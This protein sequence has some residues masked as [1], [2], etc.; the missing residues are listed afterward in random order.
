MSPG[1]STMASCED[2]NS[3]LARNTSPDHLIRIV[4]FRLGHCF[5]CIMYRPIVFLNSL[6]QNR[7]YGIVACIAHKLK[8]LVPVGESELELR[9]IS[10]LRSEKLECILGI[11][12]RNEK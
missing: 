2:V 11:L 7:T 9:L 10:S 12:V 8:G 5:A 6:P 3:F 4:R 1:G